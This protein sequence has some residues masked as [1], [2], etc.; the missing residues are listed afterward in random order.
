MDVIHKHGIGSCKG[1]LI[2]TPQGLRYDTTNKGDAFTV[3]LANLDQF[4]VDYLDKNLKIKIKGGKQY[5]FTDP[6]GNADHL[7]VFHRDVEKAR[8]RLKKGDRPGP[9]TAIVSVRG[10][11]AGVP[12][13]PDLLFGDP[14]GITCQIQNPAISSFVSAKG[15][16]MTV[17]LVPENL[18]RAP[19]ELGWS[20]SP[21]SITP[22]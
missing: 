15:P 14:D 12:G 4:A 19:F 2:A 9:L 1:T 10:A 20:P 18:T 13:T 6:Q 8:E 16:S 7:F 17:R 11:S 3:P 21:A 5:N 22:L